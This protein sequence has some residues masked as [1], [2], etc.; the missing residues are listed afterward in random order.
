MIIGGL[1][2]ISLWGVGDVE[3]DGFRVS[4]GVVA[5][6]A[7]D[8]KVGVGVWLGSGSTVGVRA[9]VGDGVGVSIVSGVEVSVGPTLGVSLA[10]SVPA[11]TPAAV[12][13]GAPFSTTIVS[14]IVV[15]PQAARSR[16]RPA[17]VSVQSNF[18]TIMILLPVETLWGYC[19]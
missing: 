1:S 6:M 15:V 7:V 4:V 9:S 13:L 18:L 8:V 16:A 5:E 3:G 11:D 2:S 10:A 17:S 19:T 14:L 12:A